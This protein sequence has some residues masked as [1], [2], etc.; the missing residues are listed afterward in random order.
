MKTVRDREAADRQKIIELIEAAKEAEREAIGIRV[1]AEA[2]KSAAADRAEAVREQARGAADQTR[3]KAEAEAEAVRAAAEAAR[4]R[5]EVDAAGQNALNAAANLL[6]PE[7]IAMQIR[8]KLIENLDRIIAESVKPMENIDSIKIVQVEGLNGGGGAGASA[9]GQDGGSLSDQVVS[10][11]LRYR[12]QA[13]LV[14]QLMAEVGLSGSDL[15]GL[16]GA[17]R[18]APKT[19]APQPEPTPSAK[20]KPAAKS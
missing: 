3:I 13:P 9:G 18:T 6:S 16:T 17:L 12:A 7:Q 14:D 20:A 15:D 8:I 19:E 2:E 11:A 1:A 4:L 5:Y 10:S